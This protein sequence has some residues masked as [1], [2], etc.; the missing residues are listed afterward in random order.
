MT[1]TKRNKPKT[2]NS[3]KANRING[4][5]W[6]SE[7]IHASDKESWKKCGTKKKETDGR[8]IVEAEKHQGIWFKN[9]KIKLSKC[10]DYSNATLLN[11]IGGWMVG[12]CISKCICIILWCESSNMV[13]I[14]TP[15]LIWLMATEWRPLFK[16]KYKSSE[17]LRN[18]LQKKLLWKKKNWNGLSQYSV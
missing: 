12:L 18:R 15:H 2:N 10:K 5:R 1:R 8:Q 6:N 9:K 14:Y 17:V 11:C 7:K 13:S 3:S 4:K 16:L